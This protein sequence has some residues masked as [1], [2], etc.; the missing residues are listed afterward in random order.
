MTSGDATR[1]Y[2]T[3]RRSAVALVARA[4]ASRTQIGLYLRDAGFEVLECEEL[5]IVSRFI[6]IVLVD[7][8]SGEGAAHAQ[9]RSWL[10]SAAPLRVVVISSKPVRWR[11]LSLVFGDRLTVLAPPAFG[12][13]IV[14]ALRPPPA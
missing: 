9:V 4:D 13:D 7:H 10:E 2:R 8:A 3:R 12:W 6:G 5:A 1:T 11:T 14:D